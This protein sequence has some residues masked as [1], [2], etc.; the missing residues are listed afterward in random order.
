MG[1]MFWYWLLEIVDMTC[2]DFIIVVDVLLLYQHAY[3]LLPLLM[4]K[5]VVVSIYRN[6]KL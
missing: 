1:C 3:Y 4:L 6:R 2:L 5:M